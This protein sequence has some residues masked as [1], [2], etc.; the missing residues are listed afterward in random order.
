MITKI[1]ECGCG[2]EVKKVGGRYATRKCYIGDYEMSP[3]MFRQKGKAN[4]IKLLALMEGDP[5]ALS[6]AEYNN[7]TFWARKGVGEWRVK[8]GLV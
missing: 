2:K 7:I 6:W 5:E 3:N 4:D 1:C 8:D